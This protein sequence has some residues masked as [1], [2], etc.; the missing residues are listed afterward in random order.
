MTEFKV[1]RVH[2][3]PSEDDGRRILVDRLW[4]RGI[5]KQAA[6]IDDWPKDATPSTELRNAYH[7]GEVD[8]AEF[9][10]RYRTELETSGAAVALALDLSGTV[11][12]VTAV[13]EPDHG[14]VP[15]LRQAL[16]EAI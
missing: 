1:K 12:L 3:D 15:V 14:H 8:E 11:T 9:A 7:H 10:E 6:K 5:S 2:E 16:T 4:P 13:K